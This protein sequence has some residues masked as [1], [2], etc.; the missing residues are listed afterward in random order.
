[1]SNEKNPAYLTVSQVAERWSVSE[2]F[3]RRLIWDGELTATCFGRA[4]RVSRE[5]VSRYAAA[6][7]RTHAQP[8]GALRHTKPV[9][10]R[11]GS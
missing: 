3:V 8:P 11:S 7:I 6:A 5:E 10:G 4:V 2:N 9:R 1:M